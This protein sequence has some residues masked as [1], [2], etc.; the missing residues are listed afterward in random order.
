M[1]NNKA[2]KINATAKVTGSK[3]GAKREAAK[4]ARRLFTRV[5]R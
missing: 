4:K 2:I 1:T 3:K 5:P